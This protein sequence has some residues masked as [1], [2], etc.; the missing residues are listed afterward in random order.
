MPLTKRFS[1]IPGV[2]LA[3]LALL[4]G[5]QCS[6]A[7]EKEA[8]EGVSEGAPSQDP[9]ETEVSDNGTASDP[10]TSPDLGSDRPRDEYGIPLDAPVSA[11]A[12]AKVGQMMEAFRPIDLELTSD[13]HDRQIFEQ[14]EV[15]QELLKMGPEV[16]RAALHAY[17]G[18]Q[19]EPMLVRR[20][21]LWL[22]G[23][24]APQEAENLLAHLMDTYGYDFSDRTEASLVLAESSPDR[25]MEIARP[26]LERRERLTKWMPDDEFLV[27]GWVNA[28][29]VK[30]TSPVPMLADVATN[31]MIM[32]N[33]RTLAAKRLGDFPN[34]MIGQRALET[35]LIESSGDH[36]IRRMAAQS[37]LKL[38]ARETACSLFEET[39]VREQDPGMAQFLQDMVQKNC[40]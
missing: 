28:N 3:T 2:G 37:L 8:S 9:S 17:T 11:A 39:L 12:R 23:K 30:G 19:D 36:Y 14:R 6:P 13:H 29:I 26:Y 27:Q 21:L 32:P 10:G 31:L 16:G 33:A 22:G 20:S 18:A 15:Y 4:L 24:T 40:R 5:S 34:E 35:C 7:P 38:L 1:A 25:F